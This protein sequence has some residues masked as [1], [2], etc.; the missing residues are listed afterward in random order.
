[1]SSAGMKHH[2]HRPFEEEMFYCTHSS[3]SHNPSSKAGRAGICRQE[4]TQRPWMSV[5]Y[6]LDPHPH[7]FL[8]LPRDVTNHSELSLPTLIITQEN[9]LQ[10]CLNFIKV[11]KKAFSQ[12]RVTLPRLLST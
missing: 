8:I 3:I 5:L 6:C 1:M 2:D 10:T 7:G 9:V 11:Y 12:L 4:L